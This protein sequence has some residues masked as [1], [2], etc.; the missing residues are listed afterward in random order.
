M[1]GTAL[2]M[3]GKRERGGAPALVFM[4]GLVHGC[5]LAVGLRELLADTGPNVA[6]SLVSFNVG[7][8]AG[9]LLVG[10][11]VWLLLA[12]ARR[13]V[14]GRDDGMRRCVALGVAL[15]SLVWVMERTGPVWDALQ[16]GFA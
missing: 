11:A 8:E 5:G 3:L 2:L 16:A 4:V 9:Q 14:P 1:L 10:A 13:V 12:G 6:A 15:V 7:V